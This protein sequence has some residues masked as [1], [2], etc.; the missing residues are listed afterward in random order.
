MCLD[1][2]VYRPEEGI[3]STGWVL[4]LNSGTLK[5]RWA[6]LTA[7]ASLQLALY[8][9]SRVSPA[10][11]SP[12]HS[13]FTHSVYFYSSKWERNAT[14]Q[15][16]TNHSSQTRILWQSPTY[17]TQ[18]SRSVG[19]ARRARSSRVPL[20]EGQASL[21]EALMIVHTCR[22]LLQARWHL[23]SPESTCHHR[24]RRHGAVHGA[25]GFQCLTVYIMKLLPKTLHCKL[26][27]LHCILGKTVN[28]N[29]YYKQTAK[30]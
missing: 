2:Y 18:R 9:F 14:C 7:E 15:G 17:S 10:Q 30:H 22:L 20:D 19:A 1:K 26:C 8:L 3:G 28:T 27:Y 12:G 24:P 11:N 4:R 6:L 23:E 25:C 13:Y 29:G 16:I 21:G 5:D